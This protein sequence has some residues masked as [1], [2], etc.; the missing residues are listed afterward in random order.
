MCKHIITWL[1]V[2]AIVIALLQFT[3]LRFLP[4]DAADFADGVAF[5][6]LI[7]TVFSWIAA[8][9]NDGK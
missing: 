7:G 4:K 5:G 9:R 8:G 3:P 6:L 2:I 1:T